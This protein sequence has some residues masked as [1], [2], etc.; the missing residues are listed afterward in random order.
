MSARLYQEEASFLLVLSN[1][2]LRLITWM[3]GLP[4]IFWI[5]QNIPLT[6]KPILYGIC[7]HVVSSIT[8]GGLFFGL[9]WAAIYFIGRLTNEY[10]DIP[11][12]EWMLEAPFY[13]YGTNLVDV[14]YYWILIFLALVGAQKKNEFRAQQLA[15]EKKK[16][17]S[18]LEAK[19]TR[20]ELEHLRLQLHPHFFFNTLN[21]ISALIRLGNQDGAQKVLAD[22]GSL[23]RRAFHFKS[24]ERIS[25]KEEIL[26]LET[27]LSIEKVRLGG[28]LNFE[29]HIEKKS[30]AAAIPALLLQPLLENSIIHGVA[31]VE[32]GG[33]VRLDIHESADQ[34]R[35]EINIY[36]PGRLG[37]ERAGSIGV[38][39][40][41]SRLSAHYGEEFIFHLRDRPA[42]GVLTRIEIPFETTS[43]YS[44]NSKIESIES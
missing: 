15:N 9:R 20:A 11:F 3:F 5:H 30:E 7:F 28:R 12:V 39:N 6:R 10:E 16:Q 25:I 24:G 26:G 14:V 29:I 37:P 8:F 22:L 40:T 17:I 36:N 23:L 4:L 42:G 13:Y 34:T 27:Y 43:N 32:E 35:V 21:S 1:Q 18:L 38:S 2:Y 33:T 44:E 19:V 41:K 31:K